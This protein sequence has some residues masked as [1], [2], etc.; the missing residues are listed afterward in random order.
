MVVAS[1]LID[2]TTHFSFEISLK[3]CNIL[4][5]MNRLKLNVMSFFK[6]F[7]CPIFSIIVF[8]FMVNCDFVNDM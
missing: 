3:Q 5:Y 1:R 2:S 6:F 8:V 7:F 4:G